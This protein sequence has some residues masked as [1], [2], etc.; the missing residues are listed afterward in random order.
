MAGAGEA[1]LRAAVGNSGTVA[2]TG[3]S[4]AATGP[5]AVTGS[6]AVTCL[7]IAQEQTP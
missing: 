5:E 3:G 7:G 4:P 1:P 2:R 6:E